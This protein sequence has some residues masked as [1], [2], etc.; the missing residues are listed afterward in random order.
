M[1]KQTL[2]GHPIQLVFVGVKELQAKTFTPPSPD[3]EFKIE[4]KDVKMNVSHG[5]YDKERRLLPVQITVEIGK[6]NQKTCKLPLYIKVAIIGI[7]ENDEKDPHVDAF[8]RFVQ[9]NAVHL[10]HP[11][12][13]EHVFALSARC[14]VRP[15][16]LP[17]V[18][19]AS[20]FQKKIT[21]N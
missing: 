3:N 5:E 6:S 11:F 17:L 18:T 12:L 8:H 4:T 14:G 2:K 21:E 13:R 20:V 7:F 16:I 15:I 10:L 19:V 1:V 9:K